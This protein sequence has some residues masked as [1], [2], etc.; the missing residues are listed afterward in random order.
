MTFSY[1][2]TAAVLKICETQV[3]DLIVDLTRICE[4]RIGILTQKA[5]E[6]AMRILAV[7]GNLDTAQLVL[8]AQMPPKKV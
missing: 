6:E 1:N 7:D 5:A 8:D 4:Q 2:V 3:D